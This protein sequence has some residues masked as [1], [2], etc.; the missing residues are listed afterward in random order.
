MG[1]G[2]ALTGGMEAIGASL[3]S[4]VMDGDTHI[5]GV[6]DI[7]A[8][9]TPITGIMAIGMVITITTITVMDTITA[10]HITEEEEIHPMPI[11]GI[12]I[13]EGQTSVLEE[14]P[15][16]DWRAIEGIHLITIIPEGQKAIRSPVEE[17]LFHLK[18]TRCQ[19]EEVG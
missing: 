16:P 13:V 4:M 12:P 17:T 7:M 2:I 8:G 9:V 10:M 5:I 1:I 19:I 15:T 3:I 14:I 11:A 6:L 18:E